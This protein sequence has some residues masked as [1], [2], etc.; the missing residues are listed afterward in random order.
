M[1]FRSTVPYGTIPNKA[2]PEADVIG[3]KILLPAEY[4]MRSAYTGYPALETFRQTMLAYSSESPFIGSQG[5][6]VLFFTQDTDVR[7]VFIQLTGKTF[8][9]PTASLIKKR[10]A[11][12]VNN[13]VNVTLVPLVSAALAELSSLGAAAEYTDLLQTRMLSA[14]YVDRVSGYAGTVLLAALVLS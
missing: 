13:D 2:L 4:R 5:R 1:L 11:L 3:N 6:C 9:I 10:T 12:Q 8:T 14:N 7:S